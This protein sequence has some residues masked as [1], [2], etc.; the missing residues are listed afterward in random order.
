M[1]YFLLVLALI[2]NQPE[3]DAWTRESVLGGLAERERKLE[4]LSFRVEMRIRYVE[5]LPEGVR[6]TP[7]SGDPDERLLALTFWKRGDRIAATIEM[8]TD[9]PFI[10]HKSKWTWDG[11]R[12]RLL[13]PERPD[14][15]FASIS[16]Q[17]LATSIDTPAFFRYGE[18]L[19][20]Y[21]HSP[22]QP[23]GANW[24]QELETLSSWI[25]RNT[26]ETTVIESKLDPRGRTI[27][28]A[29][30]RENGPYPNVHRIGF[31]PNRDFL[32]VFHERDSHDDLASPAWK[33]DRHE[34]LEARVIDG[35]W[36]PVETKKFV[37]ESKVRPGVI[38]DEV[39]AIKRL[40]LL[41]PTEEELTVD[42]PVGTTVVDMVHQVAYEIVAE[43]VVRPL[44]FMPQPDAPVVQT[45]EP[46]L[47][48]AL[49]EDAPYA[50]FVLRDILPPEEA[51][52]TTGV[53]DWKLP[54]LL[55][56]LIGCAVALALVGGVAVLRQRRR[57]A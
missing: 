3:A 36:V 14:G 45:P 49:A 30:F 54:S 29:T 7:P 26:D 4:N 25:A 1:L 19:G 10:G 16:D 23:A 22:F 5:P 41:P 8:E 17:V 51:A 12:L 38:A 48:A 42:F 6:R 24:A 57:R 11:R 40:R 13:A 34:V 9:P 32:P 27:V 33:R 56:L 46:L 50:G 43:G 44:E 21:A 28:Q 52:A 37:I 35:V 2:Q 47:R 15:V 53:S 55:S 20:L 31:D 39:Y 18:L